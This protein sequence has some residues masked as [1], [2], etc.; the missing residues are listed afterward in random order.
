MPQTKTKYLSELLF[1]FTRAEKDYIT[2]SAILTMMRCR[3][4]VVQ[5]TTH[6]SK[7]TFKHARIARYLSC[8]KCQ[9]NKDDSTPFF[10]NQPEG[11]LKGS[12]LSAEQILEVPIDRSK[13]LPT[14]EQC[15]FCKNAKV[16]ENGS[17]CVGVCRNPQN[18]PG[19]LYYP[20]T[21]QTAI[22]ACSIQLEGMREKNNPRTDHGVQILWEY[23]VESGNM[24]R[25]RYFGGSSD[26]YHFDHFLGKSLTYFDAFVFNLGHEI[27]DE[28]V[29]SDGRTLIRVI[30]KDKVEK[31][32]NWSFIM[33]K[34]TF[35]KYEGCWQ[36]LRILQCDDQWQSKYIDAG[37]NAKVLIEGI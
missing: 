25:S 16:K 24:Q 14:S 9:S 27:V 5:R 23:A 32:T 37:L 6:F 8:M 26:M 33:V 4:T 28:R 18:V 36:S 29:M 21:M 13:F 2:S 1:I 7:K 15:P 20:H 31:K 19:P 10:N 30:V 17:K 35:S 12:M 22:D 34:R 3:T 11:F